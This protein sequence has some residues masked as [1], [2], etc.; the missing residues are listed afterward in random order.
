MRIGVLTGG[1]DCPGLNAVI[2]AVVRKVEMKNGP[3]RPEC[4]EIENKFFRR[5]EIDLLNPNITSLTYNNQIRYYIE[6][7][8]L[9]LQLFL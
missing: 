8:F 7:Y 3:D 4:M 1:G 5:M 9:V 2:R 6:Y